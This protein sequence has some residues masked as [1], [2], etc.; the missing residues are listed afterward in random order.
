MPDR[1]IYNGT[2]SKSLAP[3]VRLGW[4]VVP[5]DLL[6]DVLAARKATDGMTASLVQAI[7]A[8]FLERGDLD[9]HLRRARRAY[10]ERRDALVEALARELPEARVEGVSAGLNAFVTLPP[11]LD[12][13]EVAATARRR[14]IGVYPL[15]DPLAG[16]ELRSRSLV[17]GYGMFRPDQIDEGIRTLAVAVAGLA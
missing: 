15:A 4:L 6:D 13:A 2:L 9:R 12:S 8:V 7:F 11:G 14:G 1:V 10:H 5:P 16:P 3:G 17:L